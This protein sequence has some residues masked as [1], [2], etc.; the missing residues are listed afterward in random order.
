[1]QK[2]FHDWE[3]GTYRRNF[4]MRSISSNSVLFFRF[5]LLS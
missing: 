1:M 5:S 4:I 2:R 3:T